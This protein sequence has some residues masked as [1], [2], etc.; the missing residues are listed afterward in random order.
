M[1]FI[2]YKFNTNMICLVLHNKFSTSSF[3]LTFLVPG[4]TINVK[5][6][7]IFNEL[8]VSIHKQEFW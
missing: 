3:K 8:Y 5:T 6:L 4:I 2:N 7:K 1:I